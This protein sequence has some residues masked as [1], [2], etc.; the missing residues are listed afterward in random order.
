[1]LCDRSKLDYESL[2][3]GAE[4][5][6]CAQIQP[7]PFTR[8]RRLGHLKAIRLHDMEVNRVT[9]VKFVGITLDQK[10]LWKTHVKNIY[11]K[12]ARGLASYRSRA[13]KKLEWTPKM[14]DKHCNSKAKVIWADITELSIAARKLY[15]L[16][17]LVCVSI[18]GR[19]SRIDSCSFSI[20]NQKLRRYQQGRKMPTGNDG[21]KSTSKVDVATLNSKGTIHSRILRP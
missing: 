18:P 13:G 6:S 20:G 19:T 9:E 1:M 10:L 14:L 7:V 3:T 15:K 5:R 2:V 11:R 17:R 16:Q 12:T 21:W 8:K 4:K